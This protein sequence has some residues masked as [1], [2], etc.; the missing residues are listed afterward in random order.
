MQNKKINKAIKE[1]IELVS[2]E[3]SL[4]IEHSMQAIIQRMR[5][6]LTQEQV[7]Q[8]YLYNSEFMI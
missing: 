8:D 1:L 5:Y 7:L 3:E 4:T 6:E 2:E